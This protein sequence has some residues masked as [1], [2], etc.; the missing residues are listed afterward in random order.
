MK[1]DMDL[2]R[3]LLLKLESLPLAAGV[4][5]LVDP[6]DKDL[7]VPD[8]TGDEISYHLLLLRAA[9][10]IESPGSQPMN[11]GITFRRLTWEGHEFLDS[12][13]D[14]E[15]WAKTKK[16]SEHAKGF[17]LDLLAP[18]RFTPHP[19]WWRWAATSA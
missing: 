1:R 18:R 14:P 13:R 11:G 5:A 12:I 17:T 19:R 2:V 3:E 16:A 7:A 15:I 4:V 8:K 6:W 10:F 9:K